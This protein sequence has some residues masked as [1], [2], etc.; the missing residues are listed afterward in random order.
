MKTCI[1]W[2]AALSYSFAASAKDIVKIVA[3]SCMKQGKPKPALASMA[4][5]NPDI[6]LLMGDNIYADT[7][8]PNQMRQ[9]YL[10]L[11]QDPA[12]IALKAKAP[13]LATWDDHDF[14]TDDSNASNPIKN[15]SKKLF[16][17]FLGD[18]PQDL[19]NAHD[20]IYTSRT[21]GEGKKTVHVI[22]L[23]TRFNLVTMYGK[24]PLPETI[25][26]KPG[27]QILGE[28]Q[29][30]WLEKELKTPAA[31][32]IIVS[33]VQVFSNF[34]KYER[35][36]VLPDELTRLKNL[37]ALQ[38]GT[39]KNLIFLSGDRHFGEIAKYSVASDTF[40]EM[41]SS[42][43]NLDSGH[44]FP[45]ESNP[46]VLSKLGGPQYGVLDLSWGTNSVSVTLNLK[47]AEGETKG[48]QKIQFQY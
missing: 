35:W 9:G 6:T 15:I 36:S 45:K 33:S 7:T 43:L 22:M 13:I 23:D 16:L 14:S 25:Q 42:N 27:Q 12:F 30:R 38:K 37:L 17:E 28:A 34:H 21:L 24:N 41:T 18:G 29:W 20:G 5:E 31:F 19:R 11:A 40:F 10:S 4:G 32:K 1:I 3:G 2:L 44:G 48:S 46:Y 47:T 8:N 26:A 39:G